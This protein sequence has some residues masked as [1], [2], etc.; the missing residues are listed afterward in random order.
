MCPFNY[1]SFMYI[2]HVQVRYLMALAML[3]IQRSR[4]T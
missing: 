1:L 2:I 3:Y 4:D